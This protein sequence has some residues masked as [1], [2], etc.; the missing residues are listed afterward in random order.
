[1]LGEPGRGPVCGGMFIPGGGGSTGLGEAD[2][3]L[4]ALGTR[5]LLIALEF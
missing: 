1:M 5:G 4:E 2:A 3:L